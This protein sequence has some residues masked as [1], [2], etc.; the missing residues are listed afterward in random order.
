MLRVEHNVSHVYAQLEIEAVMAPLDS[1]CTS[2]LRQAPPEPALTRG[3]IWT[4]AVATGVIIMNLSAAQPL[5]GPIASSIGLDLGAAGIISTLPLL[6]YAAGVIFLVPLADLIENRRLILTTQTAA[7]LAAATTAVIAQPAPFLAAMFLLG[8]AC[9]SIQMLVPLAASMA[10]SEIRGRVVGDIMSGVMAGILLS[11]PLASLIAGAFG[12]RVFYGLSGALMAVLVLA[13]ARSLPERRPQPGIGYLTLLRSLW[14]LLRQ[15]P[16]LRMRSL[17][18]AFGLAAFTAFWTAIS[19]RLAEAPFAL[20]Q[21]GIALFALVG[22]TAAFVAPIAGR[23]GDRGWSYPATVICHVF[24]VIGFGIAALG[25]SAA[26]GGSISHLI[27]LGLAAACLDVGVIG[28]Q[29]I[30]RRAVNL[31]NPEARGRLNGLFVGLFFIG[32]G[33]GAAASGLAWSL[34]GWLA[35]CALGGMFGLGALIANLIGGSRG[36]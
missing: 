33:I 25:G 7:V 31:L 11:R 3:L 23:M 21:R 34:G 22:A 29:T 14:D 8:M 35:V 17:T 9:C 10:A 15:E 18:A 12:W 1:A 20:D 6:G 24:I 36:A 19:L 27:L 28:E 4:F 16:V 30:G 26:A 13:L 5:V 2:D 32:G